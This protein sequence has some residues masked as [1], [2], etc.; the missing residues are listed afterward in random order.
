L[1]VLPVSVSV[2]ME[3]PGLKEMTEKE[4]ISAKR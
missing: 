4:S 1:E 3:T 2:G